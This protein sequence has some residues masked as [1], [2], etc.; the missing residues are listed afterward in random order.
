MA[1]FPWVHDRRSVAVGAGLLLMLAA[2]LAA[3]TL[4]LRAQLPPIYSMADY[5]PPTASKVVS[6]DGTV[7]GTFAYER[8]TPISVGELPPHVRYAFIAAE[9]ADFYQHEGIDWWGVARAI[10]KNLRPRARLQGGSTITQQTVKTLIVGPERSLWR[11]VRE[12][13]LARRLERLLGKDAIL[14]LYLNQIYFGHGAWGVEEAAQTYFRQP[15]RSLDALQ[16]ATLAAAPKNPTRYVLDGDRPALRARRRYVLLQMAAHGWLAK[17]QVPSLTDQP[18]PSM[19]TSSPWSPLSQDYVEHVR[20]LLQGELGEEALYAGGLRIEVELD[21]KMQRAAVQAVRQGLDDLARRGRRAPQPLMH[22]AP[23]PFADAIA[24]AHRAFAARPAPARC[25]GCPDLLWVWNWQAVLPPEPD[26]QASVQSIARTLSARWARP[27]VRVAWP[28][29]GHDLARGAVLLD[30]GSQTMALAASDARALRGR[31]RGLPVTDL[32]EIYP[33]GDV[34]VVELQPLADGALRLRLV[35]HTTAQAALVAIDPASRAVRALVGAAP[36]TAA[37]GFNR[38]TQARRQPGSAFKPVLYAAALEAHAITPA[39][40]CDDSPLR[41]VD[42]ST[43]RVWRP[44]NYEDGHYDGLIAYRVAL[45]RS[46]NTCSVRL[47]QQLGIEA[48]RTMAYAMGI[49]RPLPNNLPLAL[50]TGEVTPLSLTNAMATLAAGGAYAPARFVRRVVDA[51]G[52]IVFAPAVAAPVQ[53]L[54]PQAAFVTTSLLRGV[55]EEGT[56]RKARLVGRPLAGKTGTSQDARDVWFTGYAPSLCASVWLGHDDNASL[57][58]ETGA[59]AALPTW[60]RFMGA[61]LVNEPPT[62]FFEPPHIVHVAIN[63]VTGEAVQARQGAAGV[64]SDGSPAAE[65]PAP[66]DEVFIEG[67]EPVRPGQVPASIYL[68]DDGEMR[69][70]TPDAR[71]YGGWRPGG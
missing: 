57:G 39:T 55:V 61:A 31:K 38:A 37:G 23:A 50:G 44:E 32:G 27:F 41:L 64:S 34:V 47:L 67:T 26:A 10:G 63:P 54:S 5:R 45:A 68:Q 28:V 52:H 19:P 46:K 9:D 3:G 69:G 51:E 4:A 56:A 29:V 6:Q 30:A 13:I 70:P 62:P 11:K 25:L 18:L 20:R 17:E 53:A 40:L 42:P 22:F 43:G 35:P 71:P 49:D 58:R 2:A 15:A 7:V 16:A 66:I 8:R 33:V 14:E 1:L 65:G 48:L 12:A 59:S 24:R 60:I 36:G 21:A